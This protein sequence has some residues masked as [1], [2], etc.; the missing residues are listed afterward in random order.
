M[1]HIK[2]LAFAQARDVLGFS[3]Q[4]LEVAPADTAAVDETMDDA[5]IEDE[6]EDEN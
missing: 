1:P 3:E 4:E 6:D 5:Q 2:L